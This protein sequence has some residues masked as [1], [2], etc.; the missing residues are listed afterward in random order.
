DCQES[1]AHERGES[2]DHEDLL[3]VECLTVV[4]SQ[5]RRPEWPLSSSRASRANRRTATIVPMA[6]HT[7]SAARSRV[8]KPLPVVNGLKHASNAWTKWLSGKNRAIRWS[9]S[10]SDS[11]G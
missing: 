1:S 2:H 9:H 10:G 7:A 6:P 11:M 3:A 8:E 5:S 4:C